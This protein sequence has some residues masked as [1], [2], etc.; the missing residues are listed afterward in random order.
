VT[1]VPVRVTVV[2]AVSGSFDVMVTVAVLVP[3]VDGAKVAV[4]LQEV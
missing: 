1:P 4:T 2:E 3:A